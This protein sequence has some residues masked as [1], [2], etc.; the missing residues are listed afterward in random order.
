MPGPSIVKKLNGQRNT[1][2]PSGR[3][4]HSPQE[5]RSFD[6]T[7]DIVGNHPPPLQPVTSSRYWT[8]PATRTKA[9]SDAEPSSG[10][11]AQRTFARFLRRRSGCRSGPPRPPPTSHVGAAPRLLRHEH[12][13][14]ADGGRGPHGSRPEGYSAGRTT[15]LPTLGCPL[16]RTWGPH[17]CGAAGGRAQNQ[18][19]VSGSRGVRRE[20]N[21]TASVASP[22]I[23][24]ALPSRSSKRRWQPPSSRIAWTSRRLPALQQRMPPMVLWPGGHTGR[25]C[26][27]SGAY[28][29]GVDS[30]EMCRS[31]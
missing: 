29:K 18:K 1:S 30:S 10:C 28:G 16:D 3:Y 26:T 11:L 20:A 22:R 2:R 12:H 27:C 13:R 31:S 9:L 19:A 5:A 14:R 24:S 7:P 8:P 6:T 4:G 17:L 15:S 21:G 23:V 25:D